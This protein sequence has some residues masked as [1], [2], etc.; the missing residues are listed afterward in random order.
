MDDRWFSAV[1]VEVVWASYPRYS[2]GTAEARRGDSGEACD[3]HGTQRQTRA[4]EI[5]HVVR[6]GVQRV[7][8][9][10]RF[11]LVTGSMKIDI[12]DRQESA[13]GNLRKWW[14]V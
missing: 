4:Q 13:I 6:Q 5:R 2:T 14:K 7:L 10:T 1:R 9:S 3:K 8:T 12:S 11:K